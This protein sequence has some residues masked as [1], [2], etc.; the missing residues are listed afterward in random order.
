MQ[1]YIPQNPFL[2][3]EQAYEDLRFMRE[4]DHQSSG[5]FSG[6]RT[7]HS[8]LL[9]GKKTLGSDGDRARPEHL[10]NRA[11]VSA[12]PDSQTQST[13]TEALIQNGSGGEEAKSDNL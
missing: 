8:P 13:G 10:A 4:A 2:E 5:L 3:W 9:Q 6:S 7:T 1:T 12:Y 11:G